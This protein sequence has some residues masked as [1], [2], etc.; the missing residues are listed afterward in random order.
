MLKDEPSGSQKEFCTHALS[1]FQTRELY[2][3][4][5]ATG[6]RGSFGAGNKFVFPTIVNGKVYVASNGGSGNG[7]LPGSV[8][9]FGLLSVSPPPPPPPSLPEPTPVSPSSGS[10]SAGTFAFTFSDSAGAADIVS[11]NIQINAMVTNSGACSFTYVRAANTIS[12]ADDSGNFQTPL[13]IGS[14]GTSQNS[15]C[16]VNAGASSISASGNLLTVTLVVGFTAAYDGAKYTFAE[17]QNASRNSG[18]AALGTWT[19]TSGAPPP[20]PSA[21]SV[22]PNSGSGSTQTFS[23]AYTDPNGAADIATTQVVINA[24]LS[25]TGS[26]CL[27]YARGVNELFLASDAGVWQGPLTPGVS[28]TLQNSQCTLNSGTSS[29]T[30]SGNNLTV[31]FAVTFAPGFAG[32]KNVYAEVR[33]GTVDVGW[34][35]LGTWTVP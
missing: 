18:W 28:G 19:V 15:Q 35:Q 20:A 33:S 2:N 22:T 24:T 17:V 11:A 10:G 21:V 14:S 31:N 29:V 12:L 30:P 8:A 26:C 34:V 32:G 3:T 5:Q 25:A 1:R 7:S 16:A 23:F 9:V 13:A 6:N 27:Y 4:T